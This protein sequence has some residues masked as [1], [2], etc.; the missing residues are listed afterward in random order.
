M[1]VFRDIFLLN[2]NISQLRYELGHVH[3]KNTILWIESTFFMSLLHNFIPKYLSIVQFFMSVPKYL[4]IA[5]FLPN[6]CL[7]FPPTFQTLSPYL[8]FNVNNLLLGK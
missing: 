5:Q 7:A 8:D 2:K 4:T 3:E 1:T 6:L